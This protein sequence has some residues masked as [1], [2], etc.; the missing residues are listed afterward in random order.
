MKL[1]DYWKKLFLL[2]IVAA[3]VSHGVYQVA[4]NILLQDLYTETA[5]MWRAPHQVSELVWM[6]PVSQVVMGFLFAAGYL[7]WR[8]KV[9]VEGSGLVDS[10]G[11]KTVMF[12]GWVGL[13]MGAPKVMSYVWMPFET[14][15]LPIYWMISEIVTW[16]LVSV[17]LTAVYRAPETK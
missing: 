7:Y 5:H 17:A 2:G 16:V 12:G 3:A 6:L 8:N 1:G 10:L 13:M 9:N 4:H 11:Q 15:E 14:P